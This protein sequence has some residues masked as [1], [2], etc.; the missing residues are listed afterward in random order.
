[1]SEVGQGMGGKGEGE[2]GVCGGEEVKSERGQ[3]TAQTTGT[4]E[5]EN[6]VSF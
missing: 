2:V 5:K 4:E 3:E 6:K 1:M